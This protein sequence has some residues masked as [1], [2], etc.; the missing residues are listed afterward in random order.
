MKQVEYTIKVVTPGLIYPQVI[1]DAITSQ[2]TCTATCTNFRVLPVE[3]A[4]S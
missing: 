2:V 4:T 3:K 1:I